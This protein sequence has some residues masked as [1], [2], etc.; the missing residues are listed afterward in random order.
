MENGDM[1]ALGTNNRQAGIR[2]AQYQN[3]LRLQFCHRF[4]GRCDNIAHRFA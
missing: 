2:I 1:Q 3:R 4:I